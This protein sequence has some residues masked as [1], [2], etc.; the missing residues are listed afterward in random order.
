MSRQERRFFTIRGRR[1]LLTKLQT[2]KEFGCKT[3][4]EVEK[5]WKDGEQVAGEK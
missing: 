4:E 5:I 2:K 3:E 1:Y